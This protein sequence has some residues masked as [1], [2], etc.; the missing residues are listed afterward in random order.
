[1][2]KTAEISAN[3]QTDVSVQPTRKWIAR[4]SNQRTRFAKAML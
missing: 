4:I 2:R 1:M 3:K